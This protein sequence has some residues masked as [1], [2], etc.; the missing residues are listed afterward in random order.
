MY[1]FCLVYSLAVVI[2]LKDINHMVFVIEVVQGFSELGTQVS[3]YY[4]KALLWLRQCVASLCPQSP[5]FHS[6]SVIMGF[7]VN[8]LALGQIFL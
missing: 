3:N 8:K 1:M 4:G 5:E 2:F 6:S 7:E